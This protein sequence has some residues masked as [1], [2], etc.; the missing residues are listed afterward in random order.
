MPDSELSTIR[1][2]YSSKMR[3]AIS[4][5]GVLALAPLVRVFGIRLYEE[6]LFDIVGSLRN[7]I[8]IRR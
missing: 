1:A 7:C 4:Y 6:P 8:V 3:P 2:R 5:Y